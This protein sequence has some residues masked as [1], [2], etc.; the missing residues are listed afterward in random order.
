MC[1]NSSSQSHQHHT[2]MHASPLIYSYGIRFQVSE[3]WNAKSCQHPA[4]PPYQQAKCALGSSTT[5]ATKCA[6]VEV[7]QGL[8][9]LH[10]PQNRCGCLPTPSFCFFP[11][12]LAH[13]IAELLVLKLLQ[14]RDESI[15]ITRIHEER[16]FSIIND[17][18]NSTSFG[19]HDWY[20]TG[21]GLE[22]DETKR[23]TVTW[24]DKCVGG[25]KRFAQIITTHLTGEIRVGTLEILPEILHIWTLT[26]EA[27]TSVGH[28]LEHWLDVPQTLLCPQTTDVDHEEIIWVT[29]RH[30]MAH[31]GILETRVEAIDVDS[32]PPNADAGYTV[33][34]KLFL[35]LGA[36]DQG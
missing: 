17:V 29:L 4:H 26:H 11:G 36:G 14:T 8:F 24:H 12:S 32:L 34:L 28:L 9:I 2:C 31:I 21:H 6:R 20:T 16:C 33:G 25:S 7:N 30:A 15:G 18:W 10:I 5:K 19:A 23:L 1:S 3:T 22:H 13:F 35:H 27:Q